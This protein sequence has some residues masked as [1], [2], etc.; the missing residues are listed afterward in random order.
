[1]GTPQRIDPCHETSSADVRL[2]AVARE[3]LLGVAALGIW[4]QRLR[5]TCEQGAITL[6]GQLPSFYFKQLAQSVLRG[7]PGCVHIDNRVVVDDGVED[8][9]ICAGGGMQ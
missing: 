2:A 4:S 3:R 6:A 7:L 5:V 9:T 8:P 1:M